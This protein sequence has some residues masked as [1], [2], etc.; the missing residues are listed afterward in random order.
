MKNSAMM[1]NITWN[2]KGWTGI[3][4]HKDAGA[5]HVRDTPGHESLNFDFDKE[6]IDDRVWVYGYFQTHKKPIHFEDGGLIFFYSRNL[7]T[8]KKFFVGVYGSAKIFDKKE[9]PIE[10]IR[11]HERYWA[12][13]CGKKEV[14]LRFPKYVEFDENWIKKRMGQVSYAYLD[15][16]DAARI[17]DRAIK[18]CE[19]D[20]DSELKLLQLKLIYESFNQKNYDIS[21]EDLQTRQDTDERRIAQKMKKR[22]YFKNPEKFLLTSTEP[23]R[24]SAMHYPRSPGLAVFMKYKN[25]HTCQICKVPTFQTSQGMHYTESHHILPRSKGGDDKPENIVV[26]C[27]NCHRLFHNGAK[28][29]LVRAYTKLKKKKAFTDFDVLKEKGVITEDVYDSIM[30]T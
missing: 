21:Y 7:Q 17:L 14:S 30:S 8:K 20:Q 18:Q 3:D 22:E 23:R 5:K 13:I 29:E 4:I 15:D 6:G 11:G 1:V 24:I 12:N 2:E 19:K 9:H 10:K 28:S 27:S 25:N 26:V 16:E